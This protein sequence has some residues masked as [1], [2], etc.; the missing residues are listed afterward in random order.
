MVITSLACLLSASLS[1]AQSTAAP[2]PPYSWVDP[3]T[4]HRVIQL[5]AEPNS[6]GLYFNENAFTPDGTQMIYT[7]SQSIY[8]LNLATYQSKQLVA[9]PVHD[10]VVGHKSPTVYFMKPND[11]ALY[12]VG[13]STGQ[14]VKVVDLPENAAVSSLNAD[15]TLAAGVYIEGNGFDKLK[16]PPD[17]NLKPSSIRATAM[18][19]RLAAHLPMVLF[20]LN[21]KTGEVRTV[22]KSTD[23]INHVQFSPKEPYL[24]MYCHEGLWY[25]VDR[26]WTV[27]TD[28]SHNQLIH[29]RTVNGEIAGHEFWDADGITIWYDLQI[30]RGQNFYLA[31]FNTDTGA[32]KWYSVERDAWSIHYNAT[33]DDKL[34]CGDGGDYSQ[35][36][37]S[38]NGQWIELFSPRQ[39]PVPTEIDQ[40]NLVQ[41]GF[42]VSKHLVNM[43]QHN[44]T[45]EPN[46]RFS[47]D[48]KWV[49]FNGNMTG[50]SYV[51]A[52][53]V[54]TTHP[55]ATP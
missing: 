5:T 15:E 11:T 4:N 17:P 18:D 12:A 49:I 54:A 31:S 48:K 20:T 7:A 1:L 35:V 51:Y 3:A 55:A 8:V 13:V 38:K 50:T 29:Q 24:L 40:T 34:F 6:K 25:K 39:S 43:G 27:H 32:R 14:V 41:S 45:L 28:G 37:K 46:V 42:M 53:E 21:L 19:E 23:W 9:G 10:I 33:P 44:Y 52:V 47:P 26:I 16:H 30:P 22:L 36:A 2:T